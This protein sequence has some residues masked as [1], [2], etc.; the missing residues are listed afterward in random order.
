MDK[1][2]DEYDLPKLDQEDINLN[3]S[4]TSNDI[5]SE[6]VSQQRKVQV[7]TNSLLNSTRPLK[8]LNT[9]TP[10]SSP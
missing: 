6:I 4:I 8:V 1:S 3:R 5:E 2:L 7:Q 9:N 10:P